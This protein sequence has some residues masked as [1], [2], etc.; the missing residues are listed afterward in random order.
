MPGMDL[1]PRK[2]PIAPQCCCHFFPALSL[3]GGKG[4]P[5]PSPRCQGPCT[6]AGLRRKGCPHLLLCWSLPTPSRC[7]DCFGFLKL[8][9]LGGSCDPGVSCYQVW[10][11]QLW[12][13]DP[14]L[15]QWVSW[16]DTKKAVGLSSLL[17]LTQF[18]LC[19]RGSE[20]PFLKLASGPCTRGAWPSPCASGGDYLGG[21]CHLPAPSHAPASWSWLWE[22]LVLYHHASPCA[23]E[24]SHSPASEHVHRMFSFSIFH[25]CSLILKD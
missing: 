7:A 9:S 23:G 10:R 11:P 22:V 21:G 1:L 15:S 24:S 17:T 2:C 18:A 12:G 3:S 19:P 13:C 5:H 16:K 20:M 4:A 14:G 6:G 8:P 25:L